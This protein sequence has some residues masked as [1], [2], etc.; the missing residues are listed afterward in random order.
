MGYLDFTNVKIAGKSDSVMFLP[1]KITYA[2][3]ARKIGKKFLRSTFQGK[4]G[5]QVENCQIIC[6]GNRMGPSE[7][8]N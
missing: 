6:I 1:S 8:K 2:K 7:I 3:F 5:S 4:A